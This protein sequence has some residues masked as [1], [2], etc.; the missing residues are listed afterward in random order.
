M[1]EPDW[2]GT[3][4]IVAGGPSVKPEHVAHLSQI[5]AINSA[6]QTA[7]HA[8]YL[9]FGDSRWWREF[10]KGV[11]FNGQLVT[12]QKFPTVAPRML[13]FKKG[14]PPG[15]SHERNRL[16]F[17]RTSVTAAINLLVFKGVRRIGLFGVD[18]KLI[19]GIRHNHSDAYPWPMVK[20]CFDEHDAEFH[21]ILP[22]LKRLGVEVV[23]LNPDSAITAF[24]KMRP[25][26]FHAES[27]HPD[28]ERVASRPAT[29]GSIRKRAKKARLVNRPKHDLAEVR[30]SDRVG[31]PQ[32]A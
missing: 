29:D 5:V 22:D 8:E 26:E 4:Y 21:S 7:P 3:A 31:R 12:S 14:S 11:K 2:S 6:W 20:G 23:N 15:L 30:S 19:D 16:N 32:Q 13:V 1:V 28:Q 25:E 10:G 24:P 17:R 27:L 18:G 9:L